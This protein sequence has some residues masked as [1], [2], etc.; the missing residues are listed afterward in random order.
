MTEK[1]TVVTVHGQFVTVM[2]WPSVAGYSTPLKRKVVAP[3]A[4]TVVS[5][6]RTR[7]V[8]TVAL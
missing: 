5:W 2:V 6:G 4:Q 7:V 3:P 1:L 8:V